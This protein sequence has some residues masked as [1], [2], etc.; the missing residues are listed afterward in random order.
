MLSNCYLMLS[1]SNH[2][3]L[4]YHI[5]SICTKVV[6]QWF[7]PSIFIYHNRAWT[8]QSVCF[9]VWLSDSMAHQGPNLAAWFNHNQ[10]ISSFFPPHVCIPS[11][12]SWWALLFLSHVKHH[13]KIEP[14]G[15]VP[16]PRVRVITGLQQSHRKILYMNQREFKDSCWFQKLWEN[17]EWRTQR[18]ICA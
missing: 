4:S 12:G 13:C 18:N 17:Y 5:I 3:I 11:S 15:L 14:I 10:V 8:L 7:P 1:I 2:Y 9:W 6:G 16:K